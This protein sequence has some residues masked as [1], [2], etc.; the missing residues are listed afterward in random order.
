M[1]ASGEETK[2]GHVGARLVSKCCNRVSLHSHCQFVTTLL[3]LIATISAS[4]RKLGVDFFAV[5][6]VVVV[7]FV[8]VVVVVVLG[9]ILVVA[10]V[11]A[12]V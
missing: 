7:V 5:I 9:I 3:H 10:I 4:F 2:L 8:V 1:M 12:V 6:V 11:L